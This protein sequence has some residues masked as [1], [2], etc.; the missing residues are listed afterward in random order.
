MRVKLAGDE[1]GE[2]TLAAGGVEG[3]DRMT[4]Q[5]RVLGVD[6]VGSFSRKAEKG[7]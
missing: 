7:L 1:D 5:C 2:P 4:G 3:T 6:E